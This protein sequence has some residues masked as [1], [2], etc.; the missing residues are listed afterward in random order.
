MYVYVCILYNA[1]T[2]YNSSTYTTYLLSPASHQVPMVKP[3]AGVEVGLVD[4]VITVNPT[5]A[6]M[7]ASTLH[8]TLAG[9]KDGAYISFYAAS[10][11][12]YTI[13]MAVYIQSL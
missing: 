2:T 3:I 7:K 13:L 1:F 4:G 10:V 5:K 8:L 11:Y 6:Q 12:D 9:T